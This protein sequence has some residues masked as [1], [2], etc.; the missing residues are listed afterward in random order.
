MPGWRGRW[1]RAQGGRQRTHLQNLILR[2]VVR[3]SLAGVV[4][5]VAVAEVDLDRQRT[6]LQELAQHAERVD[7]V[8]V[9]AVKHEDVLALGRL[10]VRDDDLLRAVGIGLRTHTPTVTEEGQTGCAK[11][12]GRRPRAAAAETRAT[13]AGR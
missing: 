10:V 2:Q 4:V 5:E 7:V 3:N 1:W 12:G 6:L 9:R 11:E 13:A 8:P